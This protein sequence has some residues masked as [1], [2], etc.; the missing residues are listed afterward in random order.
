M[1]VILKTFCCGPVVLTVNRIFNII[2]V[3][4]VKPQAL[5]FLKYKQGGCD[6]KG[7]EVSLC[8]LHTCTYCTFLSQVPA[9]ICSHGNGDA[10]L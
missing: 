3:V 8:M 10:A 9:D 2:P 1:S 5:S 4:L 6:I 7:S